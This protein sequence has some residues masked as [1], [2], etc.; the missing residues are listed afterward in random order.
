MTKDIDTRSVDQRP[1]AGPCVDVL[2]VDDEEEYIKTL[3]E[4]LQARG[5]KVEVAINGMEALE[6]VK[7]TTF[8]SVVLDYAMPGMDGI[9]TLKALKAVD[10]KLT[11]ILLTGKATI[12]AAIE[13]SRLGAVDVLEKPTDIETLLEKFKRVE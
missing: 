3:A 11:F 6:K 2:L 9:E 10:P 1:Q 12:K 5:L 7:T 13:A 4:R 8:Q